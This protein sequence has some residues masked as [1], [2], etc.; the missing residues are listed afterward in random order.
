MIKKSA[1]DAWWSLI[2]SDLLKDGCRGC[3]A[4]VYAIEQFLRW[5]SRSSV[6]HIWTKQP[7][8][9]AR[10]VGTKISLS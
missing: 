1:S 5:F 3:I 4:Q 9:L 2:L 6:V 7:G 8:S 10:P